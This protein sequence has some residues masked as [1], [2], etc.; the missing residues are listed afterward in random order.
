MI[1]KERLVLRPTLIQYIRGLIASIVVA[2]AGYFIFWYINIPGDFGD[3]ILTIGFLL[4]IIGG[5]TPFIILGVYIYTIK[6]SDNKIALTTDGL[7]IY[8]G[9]SKTII[10][11][12]NIENVKL[13]KGTEVQE[14][15]EGLS[16]RY[17]G[18]KLKNYNDVIKNLTGHADIGFYTGNL[19]SEL[20]SQDFKT[21][22][23][24][25]SELSEDDNIDVIIGSNRGS[26]IEHMMWN[27]KK[28]GHDLLISATDFHRY[29]STS[30]NL[31][32]EYLKIHV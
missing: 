2:V 30:I 25:W 32:N 15:I 14:G 19:R 29:P 9:E 18:M 1:I 28:C 8:T 17:I 22:K 16:T 26:L 10:P 5:L 12:N 31:I 23:H 27:R 11:W 24:L 3:A 7:E 20:S 4:M 21:M 6:K 13:V